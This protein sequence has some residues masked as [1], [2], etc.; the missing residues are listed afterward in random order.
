[1]PQTG[2]RCET[3]SSARPAVAPAASRRISDSSSSTSRGIRKWRRTR[4]RPLAPSARARGSSSQQRDHRVA[5]TPRRCRPGC[6]PCR[7]PSAAGCR[8][9]ARRRPACPSTAPRRPTR[10]KPSRSDFWITTFDSAWNALTSMLPTPTRLV[11]TW[12]CLSPAIALRMARYMSQPSGSSVAIDP[13]SASCRSGTSWRA[14]RHASMTPSGSFQG[15]KRET[16]V[17]S[18]RSVRIAD[19]LQH[20]ARGRLGQ[21]EVLGVP[22]IDRGR[23]DLRPPASADRRGRTRPS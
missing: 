9:R 21:P 14:S 20:L 1:M 6:R 2:S 8:R 23:D 12:I 18:G 16:W 10:P 3:H 5:R 13:T 19:P 15:S 11:N 4:S 7:R 17:T 22:R